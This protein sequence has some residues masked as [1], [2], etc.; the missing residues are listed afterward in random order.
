L[1][2][3]EIRKYVVEKFLGKGTP[4][5]PG[6]GHAF[7]NLADFRECGKVWLSSVQ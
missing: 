3:V 1:K 7:S 5:T 2:D 6:F 4:D